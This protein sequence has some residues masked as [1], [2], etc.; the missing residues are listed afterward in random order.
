MMDC[1][2]SKGVSPCSIEGFVNFN[3]HFLYVLYDNGGGG[4]KS[5]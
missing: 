3:L 5:T 4:L 1:S 2:E